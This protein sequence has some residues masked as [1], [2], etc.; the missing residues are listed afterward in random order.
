MNIESQLTFRELN[1]I[2][3]DRIYNLHIHTQYIY[4]K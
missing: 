3:I 1:I 2:S 4:V